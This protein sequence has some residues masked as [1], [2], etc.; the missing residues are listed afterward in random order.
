MNNAAFLGTGLLGAGM[1]ERMLRQ[2]DHVTVWNRTEAKARALQTLGANVA[3]TL[4]DAVAGAERVHMA[5]R[6]DAV[7]D[8]I[9]AQ[10]AP[11]LREG[12]MVID[13]STTAPAATAARLKRSE[14]SGIRLIHAPVFMTPRSEEHT[15]EL[16]SQR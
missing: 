2:G 10:I 11:R 15:S 3:P 12:A 16:Q 7:V 13:H 8:E 4:G 14:E 1:V 6:D 9:V 5:L